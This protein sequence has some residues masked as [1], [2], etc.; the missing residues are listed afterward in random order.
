[1]FTEVRPRSGRAALSKPF[2]AATRSICMTNVQKSAVTVDDLVER[3]EAIHSDIKRRLKAIRSA[4]AIDEVAR[5][6]DSLSRNVATVARTLETLKRPQPKIGETVSVWRFNYEDVVTG[7]VISDDGED[8]EVEVAEE[9]IPPTPEKIIPACTISATWE[10]EHEQ[11]IDWS[12]E[13][14]EVCG[15]LAEMSI[16]GAASRCDHCGAAFCTDDCR[17]KHKCK[18][19]NTTPI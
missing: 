12:G 14:C 10:E 8:I 4:D 11:W 19:E 6:K 7:K 3:C 5:L 15:D 18:C 17:H 16:D 13:Q 1:M 2:L 9:I